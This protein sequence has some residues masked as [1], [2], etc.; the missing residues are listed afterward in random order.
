[1]VATSYQEMGLLPAQRRAS[2]YDPG[3]FWSGDE[4]TLLGGFTLSGEIPVDIPSA[5]PSKGALQ[6]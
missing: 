4:L 5:P 2:W 1:V 3:R 6:G